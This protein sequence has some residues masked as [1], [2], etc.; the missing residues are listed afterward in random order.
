MLYFAYGSNMLSTRLRGR[1]QSARLYACGFLRGKTVSFNKR[2]TEDGSG[3]ANLVDSPDAVTWGV[4]YDIDDDDMPTLD[5]I[6]GGY[7]R[8]LV[9]ICR[10][11]GDV[12]EAVAYV[13]NN[14]TDDP[15]AFDWYKQ[16]LL[17]GAREHNLP[18]DYIA[19]LEQLPSKP[20][21]N[22]A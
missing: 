11:G 15:T 17:S 4:I 20:D 10:P 3:K 12:V 19:E 6:E 16:Y 1:I 9:Q 13:S 14:L 7:D 8:C 22:Q 21:P 5:R 18:Q 2:S